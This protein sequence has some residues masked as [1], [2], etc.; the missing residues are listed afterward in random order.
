VLSGVFVED[1]SKLETFEELMENRV[2][3]VSLNELGADSDTKNAL[4]V[5][6]L[7]LYYEYMLTSR[8]WPFVG[9]DPQIRTLN[10]FLLV[11][12]ATN[13]M[14]YDFPVLNNLLLEGREWG[15]GVI[16]AS[17]YLSHFKTSN[18]NY[19]EPLKT[20]V[21]HKVPSVKLA[22]LVQLGLSGAG[23]E[24]VKQVAKLKVH[25]VIYDSLGFSAATYEGLPFYRLGSPTY[26]S[27][28]N[29]TKDES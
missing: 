21:I 17:Q 8:K 13:I 11:D 9:E 3:I 22:E 26:D 1:Q 5:L 24:A 4:V 29:P 18:N 28:I 15:F 20:W 6:M 27:Q 23:D 12:E 16:L 2:T 25:Q 10:S 14:K 19:G 7:D